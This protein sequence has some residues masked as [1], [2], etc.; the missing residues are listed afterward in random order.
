[1]LG[2]VSAGDAVLRED[3]SQ[4]QTSA[5]QLSSGAMCLASVMQPISKVKLV[6]NTQRQVDLNRSGFARRRARAPPPP[7]PPTV[8][9]SASLP[10]AAPTTICRGSKNATREAR[11]RANKAFAANRRNV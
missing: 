10:M 1:M 5:H 8:W 6:S 7:Y 9:P 11:D 3:G 4:Q 2:P